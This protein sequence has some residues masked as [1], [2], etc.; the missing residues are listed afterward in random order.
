M[1]GSADCDATKLAIT[2]DDGYL[3]HFDAALML[4]RLGVN[5][6]FFVITGLRN[7]EDKPLLTA[8]PKLIKEMALMGHEIASHTRFH[9]NLTTL[10]EPEMDEEL[11]T[12]RNWLEEVTG[13]PVPGFAFPY[14]AYD[15]A[16]KKSAMRF[17]SYAR[18]AKI[19]DLNAQETYEIPVQQF[20][21]AFGMKLIEAKME[22][23]G[24]RIVV[25]VHWMSRR[26]LLVW[27]QYM[28]SLGVQFKTLKE[29]IEVSP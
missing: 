21:K 14:G 5:A 2:F 11:R 9:P 25:L 20:T 17:Y 4:K 22:G 23:R 1:K 19:G 3:E 15:A 26:S 10:S 29:L 18:T 24:R 6:T 8:R 13:S 12:S 7:W 27:V 16:A 28:K